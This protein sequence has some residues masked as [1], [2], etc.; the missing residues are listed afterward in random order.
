M[1]ANVT[2]SRK[3]TMKRHQAAPAVLS[4][5]VAA[6]RAARSRPPGRRGRLMN[7]VT[8]APAKPRIAG[9]SVSAISTEIVTAP[10]ATRPIT[11]SRGI[12][13][14]LSPSRATNTV[15]PANT[16]ALPAVATAF[17]TDS[18]IDWPSRS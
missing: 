14:T 4:G 17:A 12:P 3:R 16:T 6:S 11:R 1:P 2:G 10:A 18:S 9:S 15:A 13:T 8:L 5:C 7:R